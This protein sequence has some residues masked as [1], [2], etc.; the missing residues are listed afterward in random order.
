MSTDEIPELDWR[1]ITAGVTD[2]DELQ[3]LRRAYTAG[4]YRQKQLDLEALSG[5]RAPHTA[6]SM[7]FWRV[8]PRERNHAK[9]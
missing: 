7:P 6:P 9:T 2:P 4:A 5:V 8:K 1:F 3:R